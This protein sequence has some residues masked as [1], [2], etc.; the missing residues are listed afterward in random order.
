MPAQM[1]D[2]KELRDFYNGVYIKGDIHDSEKLYKWIIKLLRAEKG[3]KLLDIACGSGWLLKAAERAGLS[4]YGLDIS[5]EAV[6]KAKMN[7]LDSE[8]TA[9]D[10]EDLP[11]PDNSFE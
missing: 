8:I 4:T 7:A 9:G 1:T 2:A 10:G 3:K 6:K 11:W 5:D